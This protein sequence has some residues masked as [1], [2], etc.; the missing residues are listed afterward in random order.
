MSCQILEKVKNILLTTHLC[1]V[2]TLIV[3]PIEFMCDRL[4]GTESV[5]KSRDLRNF[6]K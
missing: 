4:V 1:L 6:S 5:L 2:F 3:C